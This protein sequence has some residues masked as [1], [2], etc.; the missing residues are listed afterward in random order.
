MRE[1]ALLYTVS[2]GFVTFKQGRYGADSSTDMQKP[3]RKRVKF[4]CLV[5]KVLAMLKKQVPI[6]Y[7]KWKNSL[8][9]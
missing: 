3:L 1:S 2:T 8:S 7:K 6:L 4:T 5:D 9:N